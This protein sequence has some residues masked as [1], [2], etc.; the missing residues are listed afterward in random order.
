MVYF[1]IIK[2]YRSLQLFLIVLISLI[3]LIILFSVCKLLSNYEVYDTLM[4]MVS[5]L[6]AVTASIIAVSIPFLMKELDNNEKKKKTITIQEKCY[7]ALHKISQVYIDNLDKKSG[8]SKN[9]S[10]IEMSTISNSL[11]LL[12]EFKKVLFD[13]D[14]S[15]DDILLDVNINR[16]MK[17]IYVGDRCRIYTQIENNNPLYINIEID[18]QKVKNHDEIVSFLGVVKSK[19]I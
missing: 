11:N 6:A 8:N 17:F 14:I 18:G 13:L 2:K 10:I 4:G 7:N 12:K 9:F 19:I 3:I 1:K 5:I 16:V 15:Y